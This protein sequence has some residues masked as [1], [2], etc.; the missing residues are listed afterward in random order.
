MRTIIRI[1]NCLILEK[2]LLGGNSNEK[3][4]DFSIDDGYYFKY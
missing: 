3:I 1:A 4:T 2:Q